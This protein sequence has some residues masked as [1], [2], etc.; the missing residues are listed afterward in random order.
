MHT[1]KHIYTDG[2]TECHGYVTWDETI[3][4]PRPG[5]LIS[6]AWAGLSEY[7]CAKAREFADMGYVGFAVDNYGS[8]RL[9]ANNDENAA[10]MTPFIE[11]RARLR[12]RLLAGLHAMKDLPLV[13]S[14]RCAAMG[15]CFGGLCALD[16]ARAGAD[17]RGVISVHGLLRGTDDLKNEPIGAKVLVLHGAADPMVSDEECSAFVAEMNDANVDWQ[18]HVYGRT[19]H[20][21]TN[22]EADDVAFGVKYNADADR[23]SSQ[24]MSNFFEEVLH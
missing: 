3:T 2:D 23:R 18:M 15:Y 14:A 4:G 10:L 22:P 7:E 8:G 20:A 6:H 11:N 21:F 16:I 5:I 19:L 1:E 24:A 12:K 17:V 13:D 9:G